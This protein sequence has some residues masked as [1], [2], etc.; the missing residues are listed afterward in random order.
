MQPREGIPPPSG[1]SASPSPAGRVAPARRL[2]I[3]AVVP[4]LLIVLIIGLAAA[5]VAFMLAPTVV[6]LNEGLQRLSDRLEAEGATF[7]KLPRPPERSVIYANDGKTVLATVYLDENRQIV[8]LH[9]VAPVAQRAVLAIEDHGFFDHGPLN[10]ESVLRALIANLG[11]G[12]IVQGGSTITQQLVKNTLIASPRQ[13]YARKLQ[14]AGLAIRME[15]RYTKQQILEMYLNEVY[16]GNGVYGIGTAAEY[17]FDTPVSKV[18]LAQAATLAGLIAAPETYDPLRHA[19]RARRRRDT[20]LR[21]M[22]VFDA[23]SAKKI[24]AARH[25]HLGVSRGAAFAAD[26]TRPF[27]VTSI[28]RQI[29]SDDDGAFDAFGRTEKQRIHT[30]YQGGLNITTTLDPRWQSWAQRAAQ[31]H[32]PDERGAPDGA[33]VSVEN[34]TGAVRTLLSG[35]DYSRDQLNLASASRQ[36]GSSFKPF[37]LV[38]AF[39]EGLSPKTTF[40][41]HSPLHLP[42]WDNGCRCVQNAEPGGGGRIDLWQATEKS[43][44]VVFAQ[45]ALKVG[46]DA[47]VKAAHDMGI[48]SPLLAVP[49]ITLGSN[50]VSPLDMASAYQTLANGGRHCEPFMV[51]RVEDSAGVLYR[52]RPRCRQVVAPEIAHLVTAMLERVVGPGGTGSAAAIG[53]PVAGKTGT[54]QDSTDAWFVGYTPQVSTAVW[55]GLPGNPGP[56]EGYFPGVSIFG[57]TIAAPIWHDYMARVMSGMP[58]QG[59]PAPPTNF[60]TVPKPA[61]ATVPDVVGLSEADARSKLQGAGFS[62]ST[63]EVDSGRRAGIVLVQS[64]HPGQRA[65]EQSTVSI[66]VSSGHRPGIGVPNVVGANV[67]EAKARLR[68]A[69]FAVAVVAQSVT[70]ADRIGHVLSQSPAPSDRAKRGATVT[71]TIGRNKPG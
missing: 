1:G 27:I 59:F 33:I 22:Q 54:T 39:R 58:A 71:I 62:V 38:A 2:A 43:V 44:N 70:Q 30:L 5:A 28:T 15:Q 47:I 19:K 67:D 68:T 35:K 23:A 26:D 63:R 57:G 45:L 18:S 41:S 65:R 8:T 42:E 20:V 12:Q 25:E 13:T 4:P 51:S 34:R 7:R 53:R 17:Y 56:M 11:S 37:T 10:G 66:D 40:E 24:E 14:E 60:G 36:T 69:G 50:D 31:T 21:A 55:V 46:P 29:L 3:V 16:F 9:D 52:H 48:T 32:L 49:S 64:P 6:G 61:K